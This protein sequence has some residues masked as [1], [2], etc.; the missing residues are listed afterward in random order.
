MPWD[1]QNFQLQGFMTL[2]IMNTHYLP[3]V[4]IKICYRILKKI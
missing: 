3:K 4:H 2:Q 1:Q